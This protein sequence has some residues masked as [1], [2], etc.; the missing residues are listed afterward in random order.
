[1]HFKY[2]MYVP[3]EVYSSYVVPA[4]IIFSAVLLFVVRPYAKLDL[5]IEKLINYEKYGVTIFV[6]G[7][8]FDLL[9]S[10]LPGVLGFFAF[11]LSN[12]KYAGAIIL[13]FSNNRNLRKVFYLAII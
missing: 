5:P 9:A 1:L 11:I 8:V 10:S 4:Y 6:I 13:Y 7:V 12:F 3:Q 2:Y